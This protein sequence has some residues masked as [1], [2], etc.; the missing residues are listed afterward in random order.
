MLV[1]HILVGLLSISL[2]IFVVF[3]TL[4]N[5]ALEE[6][7]KEVAPVENTSSKVVVQQQKTV[8]RHDLYSNSLY[9]LPLISIVEISKLN[10]I[11]KNEIDKLL[12]LSQGF[13]F[14]KMKNEDEV[15]IIFQ[16][17][18]SSIDTYSRHG[19]EFA[20]LSIDAEGTII[21]NIYQ[22]FYN[23]V[24]GEISNAIEDANSK[25]DIWK[26]DKSF[27]PYRPVKHSVYD[28][29]GKLKFTEIWNYDQ[30]EIVKYQVKNSKNKLISILKE[31]VT[32]DSN[33]RKEHIFYNDEGVVEFSISANYDGANISRFTYYNSL[34][35]DDSVII[36]SEFDEIGNK[37][38]ETIYDNDYQLLK[39]VKVDIENGERKKI[40]VYD[41]EHRLI[42]SISS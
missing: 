27:E 32:D 30:E 31:I 17:A 5:K 42:D 15:F 8:K 9:D 39:I 18:I 12:E 2:L 7:T 40:S 16:N 21:K 3:F 19:I 24:L 38:K 14:L 37:I 1:K 6:V 33:Y 4:S 13:Y 11:L 35:S 29:K 20:E 36:M 22:P 10:P 26:F 23:G 41:N 25:P 28:E 34:N